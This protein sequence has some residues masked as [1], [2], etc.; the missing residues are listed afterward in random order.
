MSR[1]LWRKFSL[2]HSNRGSSEPEVQVRQYQRVEHDSCRCIQHDT[3]SR[4]E[5][6]SSEN[7]SRMGARARRKLVGCGENARENCEK[8]GEAFDTKLFWTLAVSAVRG[9]EL[10]DKV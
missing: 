10:R 8:C 1:A 5:H 3:D 2:R 4:K 6:D 9:E 7:A